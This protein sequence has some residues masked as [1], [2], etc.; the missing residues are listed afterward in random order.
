MK[1]KKR[2]PH[3][4]IYS[5]YRRILRKLASLVKILLSQDQSCLVLL[6]SVL[7]GLNQSIVKLILRK[8]NYFFALVCKHITL[9]EIRDFEFDL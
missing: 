8:S 3:A 5:C 4:V 1:K 9:R 6:F 7:F 2:K